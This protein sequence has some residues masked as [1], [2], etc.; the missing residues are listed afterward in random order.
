MNV[1]S[2]DNERLITL[3]TTDGKLTTLTFDD[4]TNPVARDYI[5]CIQDTIN[6]WFNNNQWGTIALCVAA[7]EACLAAVAIDCLFA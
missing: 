1:Y 4:G 3:V 2:V 6:G 5:K 7:P